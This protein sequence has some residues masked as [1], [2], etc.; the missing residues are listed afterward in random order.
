MTREE[1]TELFIRGAEIDKRLPD[2]A[3]PARLKSQSLPF[4]HTQA[5]QN[6]WG[7]ERYEEERAAFWDERSTRLRTSDVSGWE[8][9]NDLILFVDS[10]SER[11]CLWHWSISK[12]GGQS[13]SR[14]CRSEGI[15]VE[16]G[17]RRKDRAIT[18]I[19]LSFARNPLQNNENDTNGLLRLGPEISDIHVNIA[20]VAQTHSWR[21][22]GAFSP[23][24]IP[25]LRDFSWAAKRNEMRRQ[26][27]EEK[28][29]AAAA[30]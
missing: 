11:R 1:I 16:T 27:A 2:T 8:K 17:R 4:I 18:H 22:D 15:H 23:I 9:C 26:R 3:Q 21:D 30:G 14:W 10:E 19:A 7:G 28:R 13:F 24:G 25:E 29:Q 20:D 5:D 6:G 12:A